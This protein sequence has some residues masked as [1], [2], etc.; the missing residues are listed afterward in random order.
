[1]IA[2][3]SKKNFFIYKVANYN[4]LLIGKLGGSN[5]LKKA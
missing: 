2:Y 5:P 1:M 3:S 4:G